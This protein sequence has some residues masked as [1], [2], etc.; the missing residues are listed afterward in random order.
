MTELEEIL[1]SA[2]FEIRD[3]RRRK[4]KPLMPEPERLTIHDLYAIA[5]WL[6]KF[7]NPSEQ[8][9]EAIKH[10]ET[11]ICKLILSIQ[12]TPKDPTA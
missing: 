10:L 12:N 11:Q 2:A 3:L 9:K 6:T 8:M 7:P 4:R 1:S 5:E